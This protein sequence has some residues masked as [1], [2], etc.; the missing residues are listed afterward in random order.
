LTTTTRL[1]TLKL[2]GVFAFAQSA[3]FAPQL[4][5]GRDS[6]DPVGSTTRELTWIGS[7]MYLSL[8]AVS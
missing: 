8:A 1:M 5:V 2:A 7:S 6:I 4:H 3:G